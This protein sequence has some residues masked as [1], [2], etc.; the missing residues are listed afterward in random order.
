MGREKSGKPGEVVQLPLKK[1][2]ADKRLRDKGR[3]QFPGLPNKDLKN[4]P[5][6][7]ST[8]IPFRRDFR[9]SDVVVEEKQPEKANKEKCIALLDA[10]G[11][12]SEELATLLQMPDKLY[13]LGSYPPAFSSDPEKGAGTL[14]NYLLY[15]AVKPIRISDYALHLGSRGSTDFCTFV[16]K[17]RKIIVHEVVTTMYAETGS[18][19]DFTDSLKKAIATVKDYESK[20]VKFDFVLVNNSRASAVEL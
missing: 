18:W 6:E 3:G 17:K 10:I 16:D 19:D 11:P 2:H 4:S 15:S 9:G 14:A 7:G 8:V 12:V 20:G 1:H 5:G 13:L